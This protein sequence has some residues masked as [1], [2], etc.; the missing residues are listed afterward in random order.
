MNSTFDPNRLRV[1]PS[2]AAELTRAMRQ[3]G[4]AGRSRPRNRS[5]E[6]VHI[7]L[8]WFEAAARSM[9]RSPAALVVGQLLYRQAMMKGTLSPPIRTKALERAGVSLPARRRALEALRVAGLVVLEPRR[10]RSPKVTLQAC[11]WLSNQVRNPQTRLT[12]R[13]NV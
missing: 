11:P 9:P 3:R 4:G 2:E 6:Y 10:H 7:E 5:G 12:E 1:A 13:P 8:P